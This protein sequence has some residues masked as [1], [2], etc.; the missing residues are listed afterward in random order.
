[1]KNSG[2]RYYAFNLPSILSGVSRIFDLG[3]TLNDYDPIFRRGPEEDLAAL[4]SD[5]IVI[6]QDFRDAMAT[7]ADSEISERLTQE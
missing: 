5:W 4:R 6:G 3:G 1:M 7:Y 2:F